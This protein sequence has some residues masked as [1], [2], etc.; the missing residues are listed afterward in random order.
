MFIRF[1]FYAKINTDEKLC[2]LNNINFIYFFVMNKYTK[3]DEKTKI[4]NNLNFKNT[5]KI[6]F[7][8]S[9]FT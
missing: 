7:R 9:I 6:Y 2:I 3:N 5:F 8:N 1:Y 4:L